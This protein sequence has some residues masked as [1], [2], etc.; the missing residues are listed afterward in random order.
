MIQT[1]KNNGQISW[2]GNGLAGQDSGRK[3]VEVH[4]TLNGL[5]GQAEA[6]TRHGSG[7]LQEDETPI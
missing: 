3:K 2:S 1:L 7:N 5:D 4:I 6:E